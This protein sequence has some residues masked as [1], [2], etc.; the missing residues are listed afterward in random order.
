MFTLH[1]TFGFDLK[2]SWVGSSKNVCSDGSK[3]IILEYTLLLNI[4][5]IRLKLSYKD[6]FV[7]YRYCNCK[8]FVMIASEVM[9]E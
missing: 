8:V 2:A 5:E 3:L 4:E 7:S 6:Q 9:S 1:C